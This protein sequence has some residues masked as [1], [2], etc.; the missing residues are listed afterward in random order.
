MRVHTPDLLTGVEVQAMQRTFGAE[1]VD[2]SSGNRRRGAWPLVE[3]EIVTVS[4]R[5]IELPNRFAGRGVQRFD[6]FLI[7]DAME[8]DQAALRDNGC[9]EALAD[10]LFPND[11]RPSRRPLRGQIGSGVDTVARGSEKL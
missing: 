9:A 8:K 2:A 5:V 10:V 1:R 11:R 3:S 4:G 7:P 6:H